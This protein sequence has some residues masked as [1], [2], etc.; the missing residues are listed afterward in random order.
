MYTKY[1]MSRFIIIFVFLRT[2]RYMYLDLLYLLFMFK[3]NITSLAEYRK[4]SC[5]DNLL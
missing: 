2:D 5:K 3:M 1:I 4:C